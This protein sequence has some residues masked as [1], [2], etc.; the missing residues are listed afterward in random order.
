[1]EF[2]NWVDVLIVAIVIVAAIRGWFQ[3]A[4]RQV[5]G[6]IGLIAGFYVGIAIAPSLSTKI[7][8]SSWRP[9]IALVIVVVAAYAGHLLGHLLGASIRRAVK[10]VK[11]GLV[12]SVA[13]VV[14]AV[15]GALV[16]VW[17][18]AALLVATSWST[19]ASGIQGSRII[20]D[21]D[22]ALPTVPSAEAKLQ[23]LLRNADFPSV[24]TSIV[25][26]TIPSS[27]PAPKLGKNTLSPRSPSQILKVLAMGCPDTHQGTAFF[28]AP[29]LVVTNAHVVAGATS[30]TVGGASA[31]V[32]LFDPVN[33]L[34][35]LRVARLMST[36][37]MSFAPSVPTSGAHAQVIGFPLNGTRTISPSIINGEI[38]AESRD[39]YD[40]QTFARTVLVVYSH[41]ALGN[42]GSPVLVRGDVTGVVFSKS[43][44][45]SETAYAIPAATVERD[46]ATTPARGTQST[47][48]CL[49]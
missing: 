1:L 39:I 43:L 22:K 3:G 44:S 20:N 21:L 34:A 35:I 2:V 15:A 25:S 29:H 4:I 18:V 47:Q 10:M 24:F 5:L 41:I 49:N 46:V 19:A 23:T 30:I 31:Q 8:H 48:S 6:W 7:S 33:D 9:V 14:V 37:P 12:D 16:T 42:S 28:I 45:Q 40:K 26:P 27:G 13:G 36:S 17:L 32:A 38:T 11:L